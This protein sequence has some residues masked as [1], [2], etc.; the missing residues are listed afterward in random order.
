M[1]VVYR[2]DLVELHHGDALDVLRRLETESVDLVV[3]DPPYG[4]EWQSNN[5]AET[6]D[7]LLGDGIDDRPNVT[8]S[9]AS[10]RM[11]QGFWFC[12]CKNKHDQ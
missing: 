8:K 10:N 2:S 3:T 7:E 6:F 5:R 11:A 4:V 12:L 9:S 1:T